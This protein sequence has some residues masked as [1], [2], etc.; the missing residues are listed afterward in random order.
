L[1]FL[2]AVTV[3]HHTKRKKILKSA[4]CDNIRS[5]AEIAH[6]TLKGNINL[7]KQH[8]NKIKKHA[9]TIRKLARKSLS[10]KKKREIIENQ[11]GGFLPL[12]VSPFLAA[13]GQKNEI[14]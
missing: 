10:L 12:L 11:K 14:D 13:T 1:E 2:K 4:S 5:I 8:R 7:S 6:N 9:S 3:G